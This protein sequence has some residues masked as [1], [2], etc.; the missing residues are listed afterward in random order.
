MRNNC[1]ESTYNIN[2]YRT[3]TNVWNTPQSTPMQAYIPYME[4]MGYTAPFQADTLR[5]SLAQELL[6]LPALDTKAQQ[7]STNSKLT[8]TSQRAPLAGGVPHKNNKKNTTTSWE[9]CSLHESVLKVLSMLI[10][11]QGITLRSIEI[12]RNHCNRTADRS[13][14][15][16]H[17][18]REKD[19]GLPTDSIQMYSYACSHSRLTHP[20]QLIA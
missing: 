7:V 2:E 1:S 14:V 3:Q 18:R 4:C 19:S 16:G 9:N 20:V 12:H 15:W 5:T 10:T 11:S 8:Q 6:H 13:S 17:E